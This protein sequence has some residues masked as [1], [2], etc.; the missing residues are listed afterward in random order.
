MERGPLVLLAAD[1]GEGGRQGRGGA[2][3][4]GEV[5]EG[6]HRDGRI[7]RRVEDEAHRPDRGD[8]AGKR[9]V[10]DRGVDPGAL[11][12]GGTRGQGGG[13]VQDRVGPLH[14][15]AV[16]EVARTAYF[17]QLVARSADADL[18]GERAR[19]LQ[20][21]VERGLQHRPELLI[22]LQPRGHGVRGGEVPV[23]VD[24]PALREVCSLYT[25]DA[26]EE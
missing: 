25:Y 13:L 8:A 19:V 2:D 20:D 5:D 21:A 15:G 16:P 14:A 23:R 1:I 3:R 26:A 22:A 6:R 9:K 11:R 12:L 24:E 17:Q 4:P 10:N 7:P 18:A